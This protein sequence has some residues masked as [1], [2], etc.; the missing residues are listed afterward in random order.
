MRQEVLQVCPVVGLVPPAVGIISGPVGDL[1]VAGQVPMMR[2][3][4]RVPQLQASRMLGQPPVDIDLHEVG[5]SEV[6][7]VEP[8]EEGGGAADG[9]EPGLQMLS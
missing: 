8:G 2:P 1:V 5:Q 9:L 6:L 4:R 3:A 7:V